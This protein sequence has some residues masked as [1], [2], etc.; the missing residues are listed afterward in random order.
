M[1]HSNVTGTLPA[2]NGSS[3]IATSRGPERVFVEPIAGLLDGAQAELPTQELAALLLALERPAAQLAGGETPDLD[4]AEAR[5][6]LSPPAE[7][8]L[9]RIRQVLGPAAERESGG[10]DAGRRARLGGWLRQ[11][12]EEVASR[13]RG[14]ALTAL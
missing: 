7:S 13:P 4:A 14:A 12:L 10:A 6:A 9:S 2:G 3:R 5:M 11:Y 8:C 1:N